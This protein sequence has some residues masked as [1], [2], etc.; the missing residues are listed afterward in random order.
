MIDWLPRLLVLLVALIVVALVVRYYAQRDVE[1]SA[2]DIA[3]YLARLERDPGAY[4]WQDPATGRTAPGVLDAAKLTAGRLDS[5]FGITG[6]ISSRIRISSSCIGEY[7]EYHDRVTFD[8]TIPFAATGAAG[9]G[10]GS[11]QRWQM[12]VTIRSTTGSCAGQ[13]LVL[14]ARPNT[15]REVGP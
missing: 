12:P 3:A 7:E 2:T 4:A 13:M 8:L 6:A 1:A 15:P 14:V 11:Y 9:A 5:F 10:G